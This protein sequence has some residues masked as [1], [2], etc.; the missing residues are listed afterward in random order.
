MTNEAGPLPSIGLGRRDTLALLA[1]LAAF[2]PSVS[3]AQAGAGAALDKAGFMAASGLVTGVEPAQLTGLGDALF[4]AFEAQRLVIVQLAAL[5]R[6]VPAVDLAV[7]VRGTPMEPVARALA[8]AWYTATVGSGA[9][10]RLISYEDALA[11]KV[12]GYDAT[13]GMCAGEFGF[14]A[15]KPVAG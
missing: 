9:G 10:A 11:W 6:T 8:A 12:A 2:R 4:A 15:E 1:G 5:A 3:L 14:W 13:P 7:A